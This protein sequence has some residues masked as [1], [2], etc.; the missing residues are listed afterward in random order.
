M[1]TVKIIKRKVDSWYVLSVMSAMIANNRGGAFL[2]RSEW[3]KN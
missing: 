3:S 2:P 1:K